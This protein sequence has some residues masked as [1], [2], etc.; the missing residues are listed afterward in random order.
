MQSPNCRQITMKS[1][2]EIFIP[3]KLKI[4]KVLRKVFVL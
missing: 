3:L 1:K 4:T 2:E